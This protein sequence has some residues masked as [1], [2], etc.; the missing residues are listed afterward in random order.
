MGIV[1]ASVQVGRVAPLVTDRGEVET[2]IRKTVVDG[3]VAA[4]RLGL[5]GD[6]QAN[7]V[8][9]GGPDKAICVYPAVHLSFWS[10][11][12]GKLVT[13]GSFGE[14]L[15]LTGIDESTACIGD[16]YVAGTTRVQISQPRTPCYKLS[17]MHQCADLADV[18]MAH[19]GTGWY[20]RVLDEGEVWAS[21]TV[22]LEERPH[23]H[24]TVTEANRI[25]FDAASDREATAS[26]L[27]PELAASWA[28]RLRLRLASDQ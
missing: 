28:D 18:V 9:H 5:A 3:R 24:L 23:P 17:A 22:S 20:F 6:S 10:A 13:G 11:H 2:A 26:L 15:T 4:H 7:T 25:Y 27:V 16:V 21:A 14:N 1:I 8:N 19:G 12:L